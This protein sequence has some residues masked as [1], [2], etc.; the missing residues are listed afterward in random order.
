MPEILRGNMLQKEQYGQP[1]Y[2]KDPHSVAAIAR[3]CGRTSFLAVKYVVVSIPP[4]T[5]AAFR[6]IIVV[7]HALGAA[8]RPRIR[9]RQ[10]PALR[11]V[12]L[13]A[14]TGL[15]QHT[16]YFALQYWDCN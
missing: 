1:Y 2:S 14:A 6:F 5:A 11:D 8:L 10:R 12:P 13:L 15:C 7:S 3:V 4:F 16:F 9:I